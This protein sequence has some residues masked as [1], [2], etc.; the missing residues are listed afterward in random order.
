MEAAALFV[1]LS[2]SAVLGGLVGARVG[3]ESYR[4]RLI[5][6]ARSAPRDAVA[7]HTISRLMRDAG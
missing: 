7:L 6:A 3:V 1:M 4:R 5:E 2:S